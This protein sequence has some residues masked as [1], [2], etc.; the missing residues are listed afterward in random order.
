MSNVGPP[1]LWSPVITTTATATALMLNTYSG[2]ISTA[3]VILSFS[4][5]GF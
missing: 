5:N 1:L 3:I 4:S 2:T